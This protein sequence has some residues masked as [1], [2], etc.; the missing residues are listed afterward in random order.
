MGATAG[1]PVPVVGALMDAAGVSV[2]NT[3]NT[4]APAP[5]SLV[6]SI[7]TC[8][9]IGIATVAAHEV[10]DDPFS[11]W[12][13]VIGGQVARVADVVCEAGDAHFSLRPSAITD[14][15]SINSSSPRVS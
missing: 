3:A 2:E 15:T 5:I 1:V 6:L 12:H 8:A 11:S 14:S 7:I 10:A 9:S 13:A 4:E